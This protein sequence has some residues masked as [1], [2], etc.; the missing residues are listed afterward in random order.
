VAMAVCALVMPI[1]DEVPEGFPGSTLWSFRTAS[2][3]TQL[4]L[5]IALAL[6][7]G[8]FAEKALGSNKRVAQAA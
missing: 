6:T 2:I 4:V 3:G 8:A 1:I 5:W 7:F